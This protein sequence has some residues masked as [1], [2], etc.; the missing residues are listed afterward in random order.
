MKSVREADV[1]NKKVIVRVDYNC[2][3]VNG[4]VSDATK[5]KASLETINYL[6]DQGAKIILLSHLGRVES[7][8]D[9]AK[10]TLE[11]VASY[12]S[13]LVSKNVY[14]LPI[15]R[16]DQLKVTI[17]SMQPGEIVVIE[18]TRYEDVPSKLE[19]SCDETLS[20]YW[21]SLGDIFVMD[22]FGSAH[23]NHSSTY[24][25]S[26]Y[27]PS[28]AGFLVIKEKEMLDNVIKQDITLIMGGS[29]VAD[30][31]KLIDNL[32]KKADKFLIG[33]AMCFT[34]LKAKGY[35]VGESY[36]EAESIEYAKRLLD[37]NGNK[38]VLPVD[39]VTKLGVRE[40]TSM[41]DDDIG[42]DIG[43][44]TIALFKDNLE[45]AKLV[46]WNGPLGKYEEDD[47]DFGTRKILEYLK[48]NKP[49]ETVLAGGDV[50]AASNKC[51]ITF[52]HMSTGGGATLEY[53]EGKEFKTL[54][55]LN[56]TL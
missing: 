26:S 11:P 1:K 13:R 12:L 33:G 34:F 31:I 18:N 39:V 32:I 7:E 16:G 40:V 42:Y 22:A 24:G 14:F 23:R 28:Y 4:E 30:K 9:K 53:L 37:E 44:K 41:D 17:D 50:I 51:N 15:T 45:N 10:N 27:L 5:I 3:I 20:K 35:N 56:G 49:E 6:I 55:K 25:I 43:S 2:P 29:K 52:S 47:Y 38:I 19:S 48:E 21:A 54:N 8:T 46:L 36:V